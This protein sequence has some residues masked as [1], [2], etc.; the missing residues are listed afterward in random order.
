MVVCIS[1]LIARKHRGIGELCATIIIAWQV[2]S[3]VDGIEVMTMV[4][5][6]HKLLSLTIYSVATSGSYLDVVLCRLNDWLRPDQKLDVESLD[7]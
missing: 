6:R 3:S 1:P 2:K 5:L 4:S 7:R